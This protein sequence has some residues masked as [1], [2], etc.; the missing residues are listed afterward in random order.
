MG[1]MTPGQ[2]CFYAGII[3]AGASLL[4]MIVSVMIMERQKKR[5]LG[6][7]DKEAE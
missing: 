1:G 2:M 7:M 6:N 3:I 5:F 4:A